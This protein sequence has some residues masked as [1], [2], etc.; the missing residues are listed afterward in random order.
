MESDWSRERYR[1]LRCLLRVQIYMRRRHRSGG[2]IMLRGKPALVVLA[3]LLLVGTLVAYYSW[4]RGS[5]VTSSSNARFEKYRQVSGFKQR[6]MPKKYKAQVGPQMQDP[7]SIE[8]RRFKDKNKFGGV[9]KMKPLEPPGQFGSREELEKGMDEDYKFRED[10]DGEGKEYF[11]D[12]DDGK[13]DPRR[14]FKIKDDVKDDPRSNFQDFSEKKMPG[15]I[16]YPQLYVKPDD[17]MIERFRKMEHMVHIDLKGAPPKIDYLISLFPL[18]AK[19]G[20]TGLL[21]EYEDM[22][23]FNN[24]LQILAANN[25]YNRDDISRLLKAAKI[26]NLKVIPLVQTFGHMEFVLK[27]PKYQNLRETAD[28]PQVI[29]PVLNGSYELINKIIEQV[30]SL[31]QDSPYLHIG[32]DEVY[33]LGKGLTAD[34]MK[35]NN[36]TKYQLFLKHVKKVAKFVK[37]K[38]PATKVMMWDDELRRMPDQMIA[39]SGLGSMVELMVWSYTPH[40]KDRFPKDMWTKYGKHFSGVWAASSFKG[41]TGSAQFFTNVSYHLENHLN[42]IQLVKEIKDI[43]PLEKFRGFAMTGWQR[44]DHFAA[45]CELL[46][47]SVPSMAVNLMAIKNGGFTADIHNV[48]SRILK[49]SRLIELDFPKKVNNSYIITQDCN[50]PGSTFYFAVQQLWGD[51][52]RYLSDAGLQSRIEGWMTNYHVKNGF[53]SPGQMKVLKKKLVKILDKLKGLKQPVQNSL[54]NIFGQDTINEWVE[55]HLTQRIDDLQDKLN[56]ANILLQSKVWN[57]RPLAGASSGKPLMPGFTQGLRQQQPQ[58]QQQQGFQRSPYN[59]VPNNGRFGNDQEYRQ[60]QSNGLQGNQNGAGNQRQS[61]DQRLQQMQ[62]FGQPLNVNVRNGRPNNQN[63]AQQTIDQRPQGNNI[64][65][66]SNQNQ[67]PFGQNAFR[68]SNLPL[69]EQNVRTVKEQIKYKNEDRFGKAG[70]NTFQQYN[71]QSGVSPKGPPAAPLGRE[72]PLANFFLQRGGE[73]NDPLKRG[74]LGKGEQQFQNKVDQMD[75]SRKDGLD[76]TRRQNGVGGSVSVRDEDKLID[77]GRSKL[78]VGQGKREFDEK[79]VDYNDGDEDA[80]QKSLRRGWRSK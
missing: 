17:A 50:F 51:M 23:P 37:T 73:R 28:T 10:T 62:N 6:N 34:F 54:S 47:S 31:H 36:L 40:P 63:G 13:D 79:G 7:P 60:G 61:Q 76:D 72:K 26:N 21:L 27:Y 2:R 52:D 29:S 44:Y 22:F 49:C 39:G 30:M 43:L 64:N 16:L 15:G 20:A 42:W 66:P 8:N 4:N 45:L 24:D 59:N 70:N 55:V 38:F 78:G 14:D 5:S 19:L 35:K 58:Q 69:G 57:K 65:I 1:L 32:C 67:K 11:K 12:K 53:S 56:K 48:T 18:M 33:E 3:L 46:P 71:A 74:D 25:A 68:Q 77:S 80:G 41:A 75:R 9:E